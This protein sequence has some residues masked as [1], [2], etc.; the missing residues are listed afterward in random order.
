L[1]I[2]GYKMNGTFDLVN[3]VMNL[4]VEERETLFK[5]IHDNPVLFKK[6]LPGADVIDYM[7]ADQPISGHPMIDHYVEWKNR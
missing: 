7:L 2:K 4:S 3:T 1:H 5:I 6:I